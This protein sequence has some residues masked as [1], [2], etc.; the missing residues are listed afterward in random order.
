[1]LIWDVNVIGL[2][3]VPAAVAAEQLKPELD[4][5][6]LVPGHRVCSGFPSDAERRLLPAPSCFPPYSALPLA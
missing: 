4:E 2:S 1:M 5:C 6:V 3:G